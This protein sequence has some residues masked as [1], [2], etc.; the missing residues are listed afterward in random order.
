MASPGNTEPESPAGL[1]QPSNEELAE[2]DEYQLDDV[3]IQFLSSQTGIHDP[4]ELKKHILQIRNEVYAVSD[5][6]K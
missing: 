5:S 1:R 2:V 6:I 3:E 4:E